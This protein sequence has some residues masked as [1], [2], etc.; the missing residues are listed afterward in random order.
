[1]STPLSRWA[2]RAPWRWPLVYLLILF[3]WGFAGAIAD[4]SVLE[5][6]L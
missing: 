4:A 5:G 2:D 6:V 3:V 1:M